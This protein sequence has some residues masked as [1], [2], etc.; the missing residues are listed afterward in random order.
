MCQKIYKELYRK[1]I[2]NVYLG[3]KYKYHKIRHFVEISFVV[4]RSLWDLL[5][6]RVIF[7]MIYTYCSLQRPS[8]QQHHRNFSLRHMSCSWRHICHRSCIRIGFDYTTL[9]WNVLCSKVGSIVCTR[10]LL[11]QRQCNFCLV[12]KIV[13]CT[14][15]DWWLTLVYR[16]SRPCPCDIFGYRTGLLRGRCCTVFR[17]FSMR[18]HVECS[19]WFVWCRR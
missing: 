5:N 11:S 4:N 14:G 3:K 16:F 13:R 8:R 18:W 10:W 2:V 6:Q 1:F 19:R 17:G 15:I 9:L 7:V 12:S